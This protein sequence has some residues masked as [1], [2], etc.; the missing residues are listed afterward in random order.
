MR[1]SREDAAATRRA[2][3]EQASRLFRARGIESVSVADVMGALGLTVGG[4]YRHFADKEQLVIEAIEAASA[5]SAARQAQIGERAPTAPVASVLLDRYLSMAHCVHPEAGCPVAALCTQIPHASAGVKHA[6]THAVQRLLDRAALAIPGETRT[7][8]E[9][10]LQAAAAMVGA[11][12]LARAV[13]DEAL[14]QELLSAVRRVVGAASPRKRRP[15]QNTE[16]EPVQ[17]QRHKRSSAPGR[18]APSAHRRSRR[19]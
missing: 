3:V 16:R 8:R 12:V 15:R 7:A 11:V 1:R 9:R 14:A 19:R 2:I 4:F 13:D 5:E 18:T 17:R 10:R 6:F